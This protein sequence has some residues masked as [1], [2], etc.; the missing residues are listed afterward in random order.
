[1]TRKV[2]IYILP[3]II[4]AALQGFS[5][6]VIRKGFFFEK[7]LDYE[8]FPEDSH[9]SR[10]ISSLA[11]NNIKSLYW[12]NINVKA[13]L[14]V[15]LNKAD[16]GRLSANIVLQDHIVGGETFFRD[17]SIDS[18]IMPDVIEGN[19]K[20]FIGNKLIA[21]QP[22]LIAFNTGH[23]QMFIS[24]TVQIEAGNLKVELEVNRFD[25]SDK[26][27]T[28]YINK[29]NLINAY[30]S[31]HMVLS[32]MLERFKSTGLSKNQNPSYLFISWEEINRVNNYAGRYHFSDKLNLTAYDPLKF[33]ALYEKS[34]RLARR[35][36]T[37]KGWLT[38]SSAVGVFDD[39]ND[40]C[41]GFAALSAYYLMRANN[42]QPYIASGFSE[43]ARV[44]TGDD[45]KQMLKDAS[46]IYDVFNKIENTPTIQ[47]V[48][49]Y[50]IEF[51]DS[52]L[53][54]NKYVATLDLLYNAGLMLEWFDE[55][56]KSP[57]YDRI[58]RNAID[59]LMSSYL[60]V[61]TMAFR[62][63]SFFMA[64]K[65]YEKALDVYELHSD[66]LKG[67]K[68]AS[69][70]FLSFIQRQT[71]MSYKMIEDQE[72]FKAINLLNRA[73][74]IGFEQEL[75]LNQHQ[76]DSAYSLSYTGLY[77]RKLDTVESMLNSNELDEALMVLDRTDQFKQ[78][79]NGYLKDVNQ[80]HFKFLAQ[81]LFDTYY[82]QGNSLMN[83]DMPEKALF[84]YIK[85][86]SIN[87][88]YIHKPNAQ[89]D[90]LIYHATVPVILDLVKQAEFEVWA[91]RIDKANELLDKAT[92]IQQKYKQEGN[93]EINE[94][95]SGLQLKIDQRHCINLSNE[96]FAIGKRAENRINSKKY[97]EAWDI[98]KTG[99][100]LITQNPECKINGEK[101]KKLL[102][103][104]QDIFSYYNLVGSINTSFEDKEYELAVAQLVEL[105][106]IYNNRN[107]R[108]FGIQSTEPRTFIHRQNNIELTMAG[109][110]HYLEKDQYKIAFTYL[111]LLKQQGAIAKETRTIQ[112]VIGKGMAKEDD[113]NNQNKVEQINTYTK[114]D[115][116][117]RYFKKAYLR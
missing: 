60:K 11:T 18:L 43:V 97:D 101:I 49:N 70:A 61:A 47:S 54:S 96:C 110:N 31:F 7:T 76:L 26:R 104:N 62:N 113:A 78:E 100:Q 84:T 79:K 44:I 55:T 41:H 27:Y 37:L 4:F 111:Q 82:Q 116:W 8:S 109:L 65:Y 107:I 48:Y 40:F 102:L 114:N 64:E 115:K 66:N 5:Q 73:E 38:K 72:Y 105:S 33:N 28:D 83:S 117:Y 98:L 50:F 57:E 34:I 29:T 32:E 53:N 1:M 45:V 2:F 67:E 3:L 46:S 93:I 21:S 68:L 15:S 10:I 88:K 74:Q 12:V 6:E 85:A 112:Q 103:E 90:S 80:L 52:T 106:E 19:L 86:K 87:D 71:E 56:T 25:Y 36:N 24:D 108:R 81:A 99:R 17:F 9:G 39:K 91:N 92:E 63:E 13:N 59:G 23:M 22:W 58:Y 94:A 42:H 20:L 14:L 69:D 51:A 30:Y 77:D 35:A 75:N 95:I 89:L 16:V